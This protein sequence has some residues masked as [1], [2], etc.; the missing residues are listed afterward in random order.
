M[1]NIIDQ[2]NAFFDKDASVVIKN[3]KLKITIDTRTLTIE[4]PTVVGAESMAQ[5]PKS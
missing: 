4:L 5:L 2:F 3:N 1:E